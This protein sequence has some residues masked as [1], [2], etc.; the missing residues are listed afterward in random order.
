M[1]SR[2]R[3]HVVTVVFVIA[4]ARGKMMSGHNRDSTADVLEMKRH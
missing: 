1:H 3:D 4:S 2:R